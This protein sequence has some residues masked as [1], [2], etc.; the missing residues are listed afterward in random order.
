LTAAAAANETAARLRIQNVATTS[1][2]TSTL[3]RVTNVQRCDELK[4]Q[5]L[6]STVKKPAACLIPSLFQFTFH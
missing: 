2:L 3:T 4:K 1:T 5:T 6:I